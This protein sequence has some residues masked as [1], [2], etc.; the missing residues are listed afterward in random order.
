MHL[1]EILKRELSALQRRAGKEKLDILETGSIRGT[2]DNYRQNDGWSTVTFAEH[3]KRYGGSFT[4]IDLDTDAAEV[5]LKSRKLA[6]HVNLVRGH[7]LDV[8]AGLTRLDGA[9]HDGEGGTVDVAFLDSDNNAS[10]IFH[11]YLIIRH[12]MRSPG[13][14]IVD[15]VDIASQEVVKG[16]EILPYARANNIPHRIIER[17][18]EDGF[19]IG[20]LVF[21]L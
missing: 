7:S 2:G 5:V 13:L 6:T 15:D 3:V 4:S 16:H 14:V 1:S 19:R 17:T 8:L 12:A 18:G 11:E 21:D 10:L 9:E 20:V